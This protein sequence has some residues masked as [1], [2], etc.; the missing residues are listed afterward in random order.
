MH[1]RTFIFI[2]IVLE[3]HAT[4]KFARS[5]VVNQQNYLCNLMFQMCPFTCIYEIYLS[6]TNIVTLFPSE[7]TPSIS[8]PVL[9]LLQQLQE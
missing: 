2:T 7:K 5:K 8:L 4:I 1:N 3:M 9:F 6:Q